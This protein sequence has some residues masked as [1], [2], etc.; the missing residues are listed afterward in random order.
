MNHF[1]DI[2]A[3][4]PFIIKQLLETAGTYKQVGTKPFLQDKTLG[5]LF[6]KPSLRTR[7]SFE[8]GI[9][10]LGGR[11][12]TLKPDEIG[13]DS[14][15]KAEDV[16]R[17]LSRYI[18]LV[19]IRTFDHKVLKRFAQASDIPVINGLTDKS[20]PCQAL[21]DV[22]TIKETFKQLTG[23]KVV[24][25][26]DP[27]NVS[28]SLSEMASV[29]G[30]SLIL[31]SP[32]KPKTLLPNVHYEKD[33]KLASKQADVVYTDTWVS[34]GQSTDSDYLSR[35]QAYQLNTDLLSHCSSRA[36]ALHCLPA[37]R[38]QEITETVIES[39]QSKV[40]D[41]AENRLHAQKAIMAW[42]MNQFD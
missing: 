39:S 32:N 37:Y 20:H 42:A 2:A 31:S 36:I 27:N 16:A 11:S 1:I 23:L 35:L 28:L 19:M 6:D 22:L 17:V 10:Q 3:I 7:V 8:V 25:L 18:D 34:M 4:D 41:Q 21:A 29:F 14:R 30:F 15:E 24:Y 12:I 26:G 40:F 9:Q 5:L 13:L 38:G 33:P